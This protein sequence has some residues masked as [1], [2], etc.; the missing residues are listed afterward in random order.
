[1]KKNELVHLITKN[2]QCTQK[3]VDDKFDEINF[4]IEE[5]AK[6]LDVGDKAKIGKYFTI[7]KFEKKARVYVNPKTKKE[8]ML[9]ATSVIKVKGTTALKELL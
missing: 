5:I 7:E 9:S 3:E 1:M 6:R 2:T 8:Q 4:F